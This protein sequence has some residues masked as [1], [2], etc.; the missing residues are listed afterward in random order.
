MSPVPKKKTRVGKE[1]LE[2]LVVGSGSPTIVLVSSSGDPMEGWHRVLGPLGESSTVFA[3][4]RPGVGGS[5]KPA[6]PQTVE[7]MV[8]TLRTLL[9]EVGLPSPYVLVGHS[10]GGLIVNLFARRFPAD[11]A[12][13][14]MLEATAPEDPAVMADNDPIIRRIARRTMGTIFGKEAN[15]ETEH[16]VRTSI[17]VE[18][19]GPF[20]AIPLIVVTGDKPAMSWM[21]WATAPEAAAARAEYQQKLAK[22]SPVGRQIIAAR[23]GHCPHFTEPEVVVAAVREALSLAQ[24][25]AT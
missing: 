25:N 22:L 9:R 1:T 23:S 11:V 21:S 6:L 8:E 2:Y 15:A 17:A 19:A 18:Q 20:P 14:V 3:Y 5:S 4:N 10:L 24:A 12:A 7:H 16:V 13:V